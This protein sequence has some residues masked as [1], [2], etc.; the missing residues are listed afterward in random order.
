MIISGRH[1]N[2]INN[3][4]CDLLINFLS[5][6]WLVIIQTIVGIS[7]A[8]TAY[9]A[10]NT[11]RRQI[12]AQRHID[13]ID[14]LN[15]TVHDFILSMTSPV[16][17]LEL[18]KIGIDSYAG[19][20]NKPQEMKNP[21]AVAFIENRGEETAKKFLEYLDTVNPIARR[22]SKLVTKGQVFGIKNYYQC[23]NACE[24]LAWSRNQIE[25]FTMTIM[26]KNSVWDNPVIQKSLENALSIDP[27]KIKSNLA[28][29]NSKILIFAQQAYGKILK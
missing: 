23:Q 27:E 21:E 5:S 9:L 14:E 3:N 4:M 26:H 20:H 2:L 28:E 16:H 10:L 12:K 8:T 17:F 13:F 11:W 1:S 15:D 19:V 22:M 24:M 18:T 7:M 25:M 29:Q 6:N